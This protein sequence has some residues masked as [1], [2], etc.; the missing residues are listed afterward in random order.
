VSQEKTEI[1][2]AQFD[3]WSEGDVETAVAHYHPEVVVVA[4]EGWPDGESTEGIEAWELQARRLRD[5]WEEVHIQVEE[6]RLVG[7]DC[8]VAQFRYVTRGRDAGISFDTPMAGV[9]FFAGDEIIRVE[10]Y[11]DLDSA[12]AAARG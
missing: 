7:A 3:A 9:F 6:L 8:V 10:Y 2:Q 5:S 11:W 12:L 4:I 1:V